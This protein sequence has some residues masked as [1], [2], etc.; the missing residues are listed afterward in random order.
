M[1]DQERDATLSLCLMA[2]FADGRKDERER[3][4]VRRIAE[5][6]SHGTDVNLAGLYQDVLLGKRDVEAVAAEL[7]SPE[8][9]QLAFEMAV[10]VC[11]AD[12]ART[13]AERAFLDRLQRA[14]GL[15][16]GEAQSF[17]ER[18]D[19]LATV[20]LDEGAPVPPGKAPPAPT[21]PG[22]DEAELDRTI[23]NH[24]ILNGALE[25]LPQ[26]LATMAIVPLQM[27]LVYAVGKAYGFELDRGHVRDFLAT[28][29]VGLGSQ[30][31]EQ[32]GRKLVGGLLGKLGGGL[33]GGLGRQA[34][35]SALSFASTY[36][37]GQ[38]AKRYYGGGR[39][40]TGEALRQTFQELLG[41]AQAL[42]ERHAGAIEQRART[43]DVSQLLTLVR[44]PL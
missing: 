42:R 29:G 41:E 27:K 1:T 23:L 10:V 28:A 9:K 16:A 5:S 12:G 24:S 2:A 13:G 3:G 38:V 39:T 25:L 31:V 6:L 35:G 30:Y 33:L 21:A 4:E 43:L 20:P 7:R 37:L 11:D 15:D 32:F 18:A 26:S 8:V 36:A 34:T 19:A 22:V 44:R 14:L 40:L 17:A